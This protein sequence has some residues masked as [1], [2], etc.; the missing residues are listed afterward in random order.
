METLLPSREELLYLRKTLTVVE[1]ADHYKKCKSIVEVWLKLHGIKYHEA[2]YGHKIPTILTDLQKDIITGTMLGDGSIPFTSGKNFSFQFT[3]STNRSDYVEYIH[4]ALIPF[5]RKIEKQKRPKPYWKNGKLLHDSIQDYTES[6]RVRTASCSI[7]TDIRRRWYVPNIYEKGAVK[8]V[9][10]DLVLNWRSTAFWFWDDGSNGDS[11]H[12]YTD[13]FIV[14]DVEFLIHRLSNDLGII[15]T[16]NLHDK[17]FTIRIAAKSRKK[18]IDGISQ[19]IPSESLK[20]K[21]KE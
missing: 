7:F 15:A 17:K 8:I 13:G 16:K 2:R 6:I 4:N 1:I 14:E 18:F 20:T 9:P 10:K 11:L 3:Q 12:I 5:S 21:V 19:F